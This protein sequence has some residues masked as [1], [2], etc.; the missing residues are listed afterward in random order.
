[1][2]E[3][4]RRYAVARI[5]SEGAGQAVGR[6]AAVKR[7]G[8]LSGASGG[9]YRMKERSEKRW[10][11]KRTLP[12][13]RDRLGPRMDSLSHGEALLIDNARGYDATVRIRMTLLTT[14][15][16]D[17]DNCTES[18]EEIIAFLRREYPQHLNFGWFNCRRISGSTDWS[19][20]A[21]GN[22]YDP[23]GTLALVIEMADA[24]VHQ[25]Q[26]GRLPLSEAIANRR[27]WT[28]ASGWEP[29]GG[30]DPHTGHAHLSA[31]PYLAGTPACA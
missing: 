11:P 5:G 17:L 7:A 24:C 25:A 14:D 2:A 6:K 20:H 9:P 23:G 10:G 16:L 26:Q 18:C 15:P 30:S 1:M 31:S 27:K 12:E 21:Y 4:V 22:A 19:Q 29:Y 28:P 8:D 13:L 3:T